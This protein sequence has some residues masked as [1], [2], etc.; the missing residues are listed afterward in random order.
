MS[1]ESNDSELEKVLGKD[2]T[3]IAPAVKEII[4]SA[5]KKARERLAK[6]IT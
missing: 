4:L 6:K 3:K 5:L 2:T 1:E